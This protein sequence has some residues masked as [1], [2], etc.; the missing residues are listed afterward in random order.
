MIQ[1]TVL[2]R[3]SYPNW[4]TTKKLTHVLQLSFNLDFIKLIRR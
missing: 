4:R 2:R 3:L 1:I